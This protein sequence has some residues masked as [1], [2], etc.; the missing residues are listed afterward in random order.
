VFD[1]IEVQVRSGIVLLTGTVA[2]APASRRAARIA[3]V[4]AGVRA[5]VNRVRTEPV[6]R[7]DSQVAREVRQ[8]LRRSPALAS[9][10]ISV[11]VTRGVVQL[12]GSITSWEEQQLA[13]SVVA[14]VRGVRFCQNQLTL[15]RTIPR[16][17]AIVAADVR[18]R[19]S[20]DPYVEH[21]PIRVDARRGVV[22]LSGRVAWPGQRKRA[23]MH[24]WVPGVTGVDADDLIVVPT[25]SGQEGLREFWPS[26][27][28]ILAAIADLLAYWPQLAAAGPTSSVVGGVVTLRGNVAT[29]ADRDAAQ[30][31]ALSAV[32]VVE[33]RSELRGPWWRA[34]PSPPPAPVK[35]NPPGRRKSGKRR[36]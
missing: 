15:A 17:A 35:V 26:D 31:M 27:A 18:A 14:A 8:A 16:T 34:S 10:P 2:V 13:E 32:G 36:P 24:A 30:A 22:S 5:V 19:L 33:V 12:R 4:L 21:A 1:R 9:M 23:I 3:R 20:R 25:L 11:V 6:R 28:D 29:L 7:P